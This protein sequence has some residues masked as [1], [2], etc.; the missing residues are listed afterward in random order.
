VLK[1]ATLG[2]VMVAVCLT[3][4]SAQSQPTGNNDFHKD[5]FYGGYSNS[6]IDEGG[7]QGLHGFEGAYTRNFTRYFGIRTGISHSFRNREV[8]LQAFDPVGGTY[9]GSQDYRRSVTNVL[10]GLQV[11]DN[12][13]TTRFKPFGYALVGIAHNRS[14]YQNFTCTSGNC[15]SNS[16]NGFSFKASDTGF[17]A[18]LGGGLDIKL[19]RRFDLRAIQVDYNPIYSNSR[20]DNNIRIGVGLVFH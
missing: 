7:R 17:A 1:Q 6:Q 3:I 4:A 2:A 19:S 8:T 10:A 15:P 20:V 16:P 11:K 13:K 9:T 5:E 18:A 14:S 12:S